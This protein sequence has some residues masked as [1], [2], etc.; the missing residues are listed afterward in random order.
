MFPIFPVKVNHFKNYVFVV[1]A[2]TVLR[3]LR[4][5][6]LILV[7]WNIKAFNLSSV[8]LL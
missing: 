1:D 8:V 7:F 5:P 4:P 2:V 6:T 3:Q